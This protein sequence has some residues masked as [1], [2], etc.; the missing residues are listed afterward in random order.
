M[1]STPF[2]RNSPHPRKRSARPLFGVGNPENTLDIATHE[3]R[4]VYWEPT[5]DDEKISGIAG[6]SDRVYQD[7]DGQYILLPKSAR[8]ASSVLGGMEAWEGEKFEVVNRLARYAVETWAE[9]GA[10]DTHATLDTLTVDRTQTVVVFL[11]PHELSNDV[12][13]MDG[14]FESNIADLAKIVDSDPNK[15]SIVRPLIVARD[16]VREQQG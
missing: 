5:P 7:N 12:R 9:F 2:Q 14:W 11:P 6:W 1:T 13:S 16:Y 10:L 3:G 15:D 4:K 8:R